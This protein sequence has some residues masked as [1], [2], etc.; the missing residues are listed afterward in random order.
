[1]RM[2]D[3]WEADVGDEQVDDGQGRRTHH[4][5]RTL[6]LSH[7][8]L[9]AAAID[10]LGAVL[11]VVEKKGHALG[12]RIVGLGKGHHVSSCGESL[13]RVAAGGKRTFWM[14]SLMICRSEYDCSC[15]RTSE[16]MEVVCP[17]NRRHG[18][19]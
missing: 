12:P 19:S 6:E 14:S 8:A 17:R 16:L 13:G 18:M 1:M 9:P 11:A 5:R 3:G 4:K 10:R 7:A 2:R 15:A